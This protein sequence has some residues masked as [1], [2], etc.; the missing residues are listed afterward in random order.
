MEP[1][2]K[3]IHSIFEVLNVHENHLTPRD[4][5]CLVKATICLKEMKNN[6]FK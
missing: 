2:Q 1:I 3:A 5:E 4:L 6:G